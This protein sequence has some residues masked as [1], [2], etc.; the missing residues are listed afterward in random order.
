LFFLGKQM[1]FLK[2][3]QIDVFINKLNFF[4]QSTSKKVVRELRLIW[5]STVLLLFHS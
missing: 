1:H 5:K 2:Q 3:G 4:R